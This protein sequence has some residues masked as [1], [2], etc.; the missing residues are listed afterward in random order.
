MVKAAS[1]GMITHLAAV[2]S[3]GSRTITDCIQIIQKNGTIRGF[4]TLDVDISIDISD[5]NGEITY[6]AGSGLTRSNISTS[7]GYSADNLS[8]EGFVKAGVIEIADIRAGD[9][10]FA[11]VRTFQVNF[12]NLSDG[13]L[14]GVRG[15]LGEISIED[16]RVSLESRS[17]KDL[18]N[19][20]IVDLAA[21]DCREDLGGPRCRTRLDPPAW[22]ATTPYT[23]RLANDA[24]TGSVIKPLAA[25][26]DRHFK[27]TTAGT[28]GGSEPVWDT[29][30]GNTTVDGSVVWTAIQ[31][32]KIEGSVNV[33]TNNGEFTITAS[34]D[35]PDSL[36]ALGVLE[37]LTGN[38]AGRKMD[39]DAGGWVLSTKTVI[40]FLDM[41]GDVVNGDTFTIQAGCDKLHGTC[42]DPFD[43]ILNFDG[44]HKLPGN[45]VFI[46]VPAPT[47]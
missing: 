23:E 31:A 38:N 4:T 30:I 20:S 10:D 40:L 43:N 33:V 25:F 44:E 19:Q 6:L 41:P 32:L 22:G 7:A 3:K 9:Y 11:E 8:L 37:W 28:S 36:L 45:K 42:T 21:P 15:H 12:L 35:S 2:A 26:N 13:I 47:V 24:N 27:C 16:I 1:A 5:G 18:L 17:L 46:P 34:I 39:L 29:T 14:K